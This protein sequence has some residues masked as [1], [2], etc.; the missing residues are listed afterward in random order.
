MEEVQIK[1]KLEN[2]AKA[3]KYMTKG[4]SGM[5]VFANIKSPVKLESLDRK[6]IDTGIKMEIPYGYEIQVRPR[7]G[8]ALKHGLTMV[9]TPGTIDSDYRGEIKLI[10]INLS[11]EVYEIK[12]NERIGQLVLKKVYKARLEKVKELDKT[13]RKENGF[14]HTGKK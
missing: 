6:L 4:S 8:L 1:I 13:V 7:S 3:P 5:D 10:M 11:N 12:P 9:N 2:G 14:G